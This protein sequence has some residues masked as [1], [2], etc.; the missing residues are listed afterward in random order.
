M[1]FVTLVKGLVMRPGAAVSTD[2][3]KLQIAANLPQS[4]AVGNLVIQPCTD[5]PVFGPGF[6]V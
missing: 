5:K 4:Q 3:L 1:E 6:R 2:V